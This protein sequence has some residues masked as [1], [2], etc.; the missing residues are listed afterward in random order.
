MKNRVFNWDFPD[1]FLLDKV[2]AESDMDELNH[3]NNIVYV[4]WCQ[5]VAW[6][7]SEKL[8]LGIDTYQA[9]DRA[10]AVTRSEFQYLKSSRV[11][12][13][14]KIA[15]WLISW[16]KKLSMTRKFQVIREDGITLLRGSMIFACIEISSGKPRRLPSEFIEAYGSAVIN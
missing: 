7:H 12:D 1:P 3:T 16:D 10:M 14:I 11:G 8:G 4:S 6:A 2:V 5:E 15:T 9:L 13:Q